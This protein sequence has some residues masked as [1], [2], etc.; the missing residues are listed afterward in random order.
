M[1]CIC[2][3]SSCE[4]VREARHV[5]PSESR[6]PRHV[7]GQWVGRVFPEPDEDAL[8]CVRSAG[9]QVSQPA[10]SVGSMALP[11]DLAE[12]QF[13]QR[14]GSPLPWQSWGSTVRYLI[15]RIAQGLPSAVLV[16]LAYV[17]H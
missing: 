1:N 7:P 13:N 11:G 10:T 12:G 9:H 16:W 5:V 15:V 3:V 14:E 8:R 2:H 4:D 6:V 17:R